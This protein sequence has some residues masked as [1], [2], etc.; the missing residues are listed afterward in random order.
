MPSGECSSATVQEV[1]EPISWAQC[2][3][4]G[5]FEQ[6]TLGEE[7]GYGSKKKGYG[8]YGEAKLVAKCPKCPQ[9]AVRRAPSPAPR[10]SVSMACN[11]KW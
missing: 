4:K 10:A 2:P 3:V 5:E 6:E 1:G 11:E 7:E 9:C 8:G